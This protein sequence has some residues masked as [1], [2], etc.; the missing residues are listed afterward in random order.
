VSATLEW[1]ELEGLGE[2]QGRPL[3]AQLFKDHLVEHRWVPS[4][5]VLGPVGEIFAPA[6]VM[7]ELQRLRLG[8]LAVQIVAETIAAV[9]RVDRN[10]ETSGILTRRDR[11]R[12]NH[13]KDTVAA[14]PNKPRSVEA[15]AREVGIS[16]SGLQRLF[17]RSEGHGVFEYVCLARL[18]R[19]PLALRA[20]EANVQAASAIAGYTNPANFATAFKRKYGFTPREALASGGRS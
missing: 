7:P 16:V 13:A 6:T 3:A 11:V 15:I 14:D 17:R 12:L 8:G 18:E 10:V 4:H 9:M 1:L 2:V 19:A 20:G 5:R